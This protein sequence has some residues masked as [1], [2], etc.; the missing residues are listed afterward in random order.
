MNTQLHIGK[1]KRVRIYI[2]SI[3][4]EKSS[5]NGNNINIVHIFKIVEYI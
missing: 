5:K 1:G 3:H 4:Q 2:A